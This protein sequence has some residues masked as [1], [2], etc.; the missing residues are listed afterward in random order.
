MDEDADLKR[1]P[2][3]SGRFG[4]ALD[5]KALPALCEQSRDRSTS[6]NSFAAGMAML[7]DDR[8]RIEQAA[9]LRR[10]LDV[11]QIDQLEQQASVPGVDRPEQRQIVVAV[12][13]GYGFALLGQ[14]LDAALLR[15][16]LS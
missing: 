12:P 5:D 16:E 4:A 7:A 15:Q 2:I 9:I 1:A 10:R 13:G 3:E 8:Q 11:Q 6:G 14:G